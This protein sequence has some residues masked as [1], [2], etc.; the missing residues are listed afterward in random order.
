MLGTI[1]R[2]AELSVARGCGFAA[3][4]IVTFMVGLSDQMHLACKAGGIATLGT[5]LI[6]AIRGLTA[7]TTPYKRTEVWVMLEADDRPQP[8]IAQRV[9]GVALRDVYLRFALHAALISA[10]L[11]GASM[12]LRLLSRAE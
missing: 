12:V 10:V 3:L 8:A 9:I 6:L 1:E 11:L 4:A 7:T 2:V 5:C